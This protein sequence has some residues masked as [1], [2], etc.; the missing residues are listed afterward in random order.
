VFV[1]NLIPH[2]P[3]EVELATLHTMAKFFIFAADIG[4]VLFH[5]LAKPAFDCIIVTR[6]KEMVYDRNTRR[7]CSRP[8]R[9]E[10][11]KTDQAVVSVRST[12]LNQLREPMHL[13]TGKILAFRRSSVPGSRHDWALVGAFTRSGQATSNLDHRVVCADL[14]AFAKRRISDAKYRR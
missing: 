5:Q 10:T 7:P 6:E 2:P 1:D 4:M 13:F 12:T 14:R 8:R 9:Q 11:K 3:T